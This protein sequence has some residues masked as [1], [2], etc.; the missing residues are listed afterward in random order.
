VP[1]S[2]TKIKRASLVLFH[3]VGAGFSAA[4]TKAAPLEAR[5]VD[6]NIDEKKWAFELYSRHLPVAGEATLLGKASPVPSD[7]DKPFK[8]E[9]DLLSGK[10]D[11]RKQLE[12]KKAVA[13][14]LTTKMTPDGAEG[15]YYKLL[16]RSNAKEHQP[17]L[18]LEY[19]D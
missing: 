1:E 8:V 17:R 18:I 12:G 9:I 4:D 10:G 16:S 13:I 3:E 6:A 11:F 5:L 2:P 19:A 14:A 7:D 15:P